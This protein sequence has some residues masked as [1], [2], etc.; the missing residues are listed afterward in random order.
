[1]S[2][3]TFEEYLKESPN[4]NLHVYKQMK[5]GAQ[6]WEV[7]RAWNHQQN[8][9]DQLRADKAKMREEYRQLERMNEYNCLTNSEIIQRLTDKNKELEGEIERLEYICPRYSEG[10]I[11]DRAVKKIKTLTAQLD[12][13]TRCMEPS[14]CP[15]WESF[16]KCQGCKNKAL[17]EKDKE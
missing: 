7:Q 15:E 9:I 4:L 3:E 8:K 1:M 17:L 16:N 5:L 13:L 6:K 11:T 10:S 2:K 14:R 12:K